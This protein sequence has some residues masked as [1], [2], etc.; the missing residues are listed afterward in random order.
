MELLV[1]FHLFLPNKLYDEIVAQT[2]LY[3]NQQRARKNDTR[4]FVPITK[5]KLMAFI[6]MNIAMGIISLPGIKDYWSHQPTLKHNWFS[7]VMS[8]SS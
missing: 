5:S 7:P 2:N 8:H 1:C 3:A 6:G 4:L